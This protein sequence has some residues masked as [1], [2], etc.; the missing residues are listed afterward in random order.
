MRSK[1][2]KILSLPNK[3]QTTTNLFVLVPTFLSLSHSKIDGTMKWTL[4]VCLFFLILVFL[5]CATAKDLKD[6]VIIC[7]SLGSKFASEH[8][9]SHRENAEMWPVG[10]PPPHSET[11]F[12]TFNKR[13]FPHNMLHPTCMHAL[14]WCFCNF[15]GA[16]VLQSESANKASIQRAVRTAGRCC[17]QGLTSPVLLTYYSERYFS[18]PSMHIINGK[19]YPKKF[20]SHK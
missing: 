15:H 8:N 6:L 17:C 11:Q 5:I 7:K 10:C 13:Q 19:D 18:V 3:F 4:K 16:S 14:A 20:S 9:S 2:T 12:W 1:W